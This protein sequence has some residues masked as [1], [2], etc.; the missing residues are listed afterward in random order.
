MKR[1]SRQC[2]SHNETNGPEAFWQSFGN[3]EPLFPAKLLKMPKDGAASLS[4]LRGA[5][6]CHHIQPKKTKKRNKEDVRSRRSRRARRARVRPL[7][8]EPLLRRPRQQLHRGAALRALL[9][10][11]SGG[12]HPRLPRPHHPP[13]PRLRLRE[14]PA[15]SR[16]R[17]RHRRPQLQ[18]RQRQAHSH[19][20]LAARPRASQVR[21]RQHLH[22]EP[23]QG[24]RQQ[25]SVRH[26]L[27]VRQHRLRE[28]CRRRPGSLQGLRFRSVR[29]AGGR[30][31]GHREGERDAPER[32][33]GVRRPL[34]AP[35]R[36]RRRPDHVQQRVRQEHS[37]VH[38]RGQAQGGLRRLRQ[39]HLRRHHEGRRRQVQGLRL[40]LLRGIRGCLRGGREAR[41]LRQD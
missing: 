30:G 6:S 24:D 9:H 11:R 16:C 22:Q 39:A 5:R 15:G 1:F 38:R 37:R 27:P 29:R 34:P 32:Q 13:F 28:G 7:R 4:I 14:L 18:P 12:V 26:L 33:A 31:A 10:H 19:H 17:A 36:A 2:S 3:H 40:C 35:Q 41:R 21:R 8:D 20:V 23:R 25:G